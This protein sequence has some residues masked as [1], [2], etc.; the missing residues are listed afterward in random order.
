MLMAPQL[1]SC[2]VFLLLVKY[3]LSTEGGFGGG[4]NVNPVT[5][6]V[7]GIGV[8]SLLV[9]VVVTG[10]N[11]TL[12]GEEWA[13]CDACFCAVCWLPCWLGCCCEIRTL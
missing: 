2:D 11:M 13:L 7:S 10:G 3:W 4:E 5:M 1:T 8:L 12:C 6:L 9:N